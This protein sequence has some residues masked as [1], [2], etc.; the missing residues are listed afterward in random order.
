LLSNRS[1][2]DLAYSSG[3]ITAIRDALIEAGTAIFGQRVDV[4]PVGHFFEYFL[5]GLALTNAL[6]LSFPPAASGCYA[7][8]FASLYGITDELHQVFIPGR[9]CDI[10]DWLVDTIAA[11]LAAII[12]LLVLHV[13]KKHANSQ[14]SK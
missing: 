3:I 12:F 9:S 13:K 5:L 2:Y 14:T 8:F 6:R 11:L 4:S 10:A 1:G 7:V